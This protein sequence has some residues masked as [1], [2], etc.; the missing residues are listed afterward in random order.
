MTEERNEHG[1]STELIQGTYREENTLWIQVQMIVLKPNL[2]K[3]LENRLDSFGTES[4]LAV[5]YEHAARNS[6]CL[7]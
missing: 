7:V 4:R 6:G 3:R 5:Y 1:K 2:G